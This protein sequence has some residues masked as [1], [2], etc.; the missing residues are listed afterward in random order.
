MIYIFRFVSRRYTEAK[1]TRQFQEERKKLA[2]LIFTP[3]ASKQRKIKAE[4]INDGYN[5][6]EIVAPNNDKVLENADV[7]TMETT[8]SNNTPIIQQ[9]EYNVEYLIQ[10]VSSSIEHDPLAIEKDPLQQSDSDADEL[11]IDEGIMNQPFKK[12]KLLHNATEHTSPLKRPID[13]QNDEPAA[14]KPK[15]EDEIEITEEIK[16]KI[17][18]INVSIEITKP[19]SSK[20]C[21][22]S[23][24]D[25]IIGMLTN[26]NQKQISGTVTYRILHRANFILECVR[27]YEVITDLTKLLK[28]IQAHEQKE[29]YMAKIDKKSL[30]RII[31][32]LAKDGHLKYMKFTLSSDFRTKEIALICDPE[33]DENHSLIRSEID[34]AKMKSFIEIDKPSSGSIKKSEQPRKKFVIDPR[35]A[36]VFGFCPKFVRMRLIHEILFYLIYEHTEEEPLTTAEEKREWL[37]SMKISFDEEIIEEMSPIY[38]KKEL[39]W[40]TFLPPIM[41]HINWPKGWTLISDLLVRLPLEYFVKCCSVTIKL[42]ELENFTKHPIRQYFLVCNLPPPI[43]TGLLFRRKYI[44]QVHDIVTRLCYIGLVQF[45]PQTF[46]EKDQVF[47][48]MNKKT[49]ILN[50]TPSKPSYH[51]ITPM[52]YER[53]AYTFENMADVEQFW[54]DLWSTCMNTRLGGRLCVTGKFVVLEPLHT[55]Q[56]MID[57]MNP[58]LPEEAVAADMGIVPGDGRGAAGLDS[59]LFAH[60][61]KNW[62]WN[63]HAEVFDAIPK[64]PM[65][66][67]VKELI[68]A[69]RVSK[70]KITR[71]PSEILKKLGPSK[72]C[73]TKPEKQRRFKIKQKTI[74]R[75]VVP[76]TMPKRRKPI[77]DE[78]DKIALTK[79][80]K[81]RTDWSPIEDHILLLCTT[82]S[83]YM[84]PNRRRQIISFTVIRDILHRL[85]K[86][87]ESKTSRACQR[88]ILYIMRNAHTK[89]SV[90]MCLEEI[91]QNENIVKIYKP[92]AD[93]LL[94]EHID[95]HEMNIV[96][97]HL[98]SQLTNIFSNLIKPANNGII[99]NNMKKFNEM[100]RICGSTAKKCICYYKDPKT[101]Q[102]ILA[103][104]IKT[105]I[106]S[107]MCCNR[108][109]VSWAYQLFQVY[110]QYPEQL[111]RSVIVKTRQEQ[112]ISIKKSYASTNRTS[113]PLSSSPYKLSIHYHNMLLSKIPF[114]S[115]HDAHILLT[116]ITEL[117]NKGK[118]DEPTLEIDNPVSGTA[119]ALMELAEKID[120]D[121]KFEIPDDVIV[122][123]Q[124]IVKDKTY[125]RVVERFYN[126][127]RDPTRVQKWEEPEARTE[128]DDEDI[129][130]ISD[131][132]KVVENP[133]T[134]NENNSDIDTKTSYGRSVTTRIA[135]H[136]MRAEGSEGIDEKSTQHMHDFFVVNG[137]RVFVDIPALQNTSNVDIEDISEDYRE[138]KTKIVPKMIAEI[139]Q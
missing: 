30:M 96:Y 61:R 71:D 66:P 102:D 57:A 81:L 91:K 34:Q 84:C 62:S 28:M 115:F 127:L 14:K 80:A 40:K 118:P 50:T 87:S 46:K 31:F 67:Q 133:V 68:G 51:E 90:N 53:H 131:S 48:Y 120:I 82:A 11:F 110:Q 47:I 63:A 65:N 38:Y 13:D 119:I 130:P 93:R 85:V 129:L 108:D 52:D 73:K 56:S 89:R 37:Q 6:G 8:N 18:K 132:S 121:F 105:I 22:K 104:V 77:Y 86:V 17:D 100:Y 32:K 60:L 117:K 43:R 111:L 64:P 114:E 7:S 101:N 83:L 58:V 94:K 33:I 123:D 103:N 78:I 23:I 116:N 76:K 72:M 24:S 95:E 49:S 26:K 21:T 97:I 54:Y 135:F 74:I 125:E 35:L 39:C 107:S 59:A 15:Y 113:M 98:V 136:M 55:K 41:Q 9:I 99:P 126:I 88:R 5:V 128:S 42:P 122:L 4:V 109:K 70:L 124:N 10:K 29:G 27:K 79:M 25:Q 69:I 137:C 2:S 12:I 45:G 112:L 138:I 36:R 1:I 75:E 134:Q 3:P 106:H 44:F 16:S 20:E 139:K 19:D 92:F